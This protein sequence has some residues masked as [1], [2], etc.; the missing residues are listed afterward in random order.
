MPA[1]SRTVPAAESEVVVGVTEVGGNGPTNGGEA[2]ITLQAPYSVMIKITG[3]SAVLFHAW[4]DEAVAEKAAA[5]KGSEA[6]KRDNLESYVHRD[7]DGYLCLPGQY[8]IGSL[9]DPR[10]GS[11]KYLQDPRS[12]RKS[13]LDLFRAGV[14]ALT[15]LAQLI[16]AGAKGPVKEWDYID[17]RR[18]MVQRQGITRERPAFSAGWSAELELMCLSPEYISSRM[19]HEA[20]VRAGQL[21]GVADFRPTFGRFQIDSFKVIDPL[22]S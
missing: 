3:T 17:R 10:N 5:K 6:K 18:V 21:V 2:D 8:V 7:E 9:T 14:V 22:E 12:P 11:A 13:A 15:E 16:P 20:L 1:R 4:N 19:L